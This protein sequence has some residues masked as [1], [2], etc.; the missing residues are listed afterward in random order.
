MVVLTF[1]LKDTF[2]VCFVVCS[3]CFEVI[4]HVFFFLDPQLPHGSGHDGS[5]QQPP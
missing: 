1:F 3:C 4:K 2:F 5:G